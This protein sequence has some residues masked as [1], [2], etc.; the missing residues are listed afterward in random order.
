M[1]EV[2][3]YPLTGKKTCGCAKCS[4]DNQQGNKF[5]R[6][7]VDPFTIT[8]EPGRKQQRI[9]W[10]KKAEE[11]SRFSEHNYQQECNSSKANDRFRTK[12]FRYY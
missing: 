10:Q 12:G 8:Q 9:A 6:G 4:S 2:L 5:N 3:H 1:A 7:E 11:Q